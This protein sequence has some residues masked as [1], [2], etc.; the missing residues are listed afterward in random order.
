MKHLVSICIPTYNGEAYLDQAL[1]SAIVQ[2]Y[3]N[4]EIIVSDDASLDGTLKIVETYKQKTNIPISVY[5]HKPQGIGANWNN[6]VKQAKGDYIKFLFQDDI[7]EP[8]CIDKMMQLALTN[9][10]IGLVYCKRRFLYDT[11]TPQLKEYISFYGNLHSYWQDLTVEQGVM[12]GVCYL[13]DKEFLNSP[14][15]KIGEPT[16]VLIKKTVF[17]TIGFFNEKLEQ[18]LDCDY[19]YR[20][21]TY[22][23]VGFIDAV[24]VGFRLHDQQAS[25]LNKA[26]QLNETSLL[27]FQYYK[28][29]FWQ[30]HWKNRWKLLKLYQPII[31][32]LVGIKRLLY[33]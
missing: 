22:Y 28:H 6:C 29:V 1:H 8:T 19:W 20:L 10:K 4:I 12:P 15:N 24:L 3:S 14:K 11:L 27:Y 9:P 21:M 17:D 30:L 2:T 23:E 33:A 5:N 18:T 32:A 25:Y 31:K 16:V 7:L 26:R 13:K